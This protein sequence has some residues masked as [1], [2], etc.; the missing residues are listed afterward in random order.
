M[1]RI[2]RAASKR[3]PQVGCG[4]M[5]IVFEWGS[6]RKVADGTKASQEWTWPV[7]CRAHAVY[8]RV[9]QQPSCSVHTC[10][11]PRRHIC[12]GIRTHTRTVRARCAARIRYCAYTAQSLPAGSWRS[13]ASPV[14]HPVSSVDRPVGVPLS[15]CARRWCWWF[16]SGLLALGV[17]RRAVVSLKLRC[18]RNANFNLGTQN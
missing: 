8:G 5:P 7:G 13:R 14:P 17:A 18:A 4:A 9:I 1:Q 6:P 10:C 12:Q 15:A 11:R 3:A 2:F 16:A